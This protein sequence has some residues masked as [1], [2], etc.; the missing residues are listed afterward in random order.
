LHTESKFPSLYFPGS[1][2]AHAVNPSVE[3]Y[4]PISH[5]LQIP[6]SVKFEEY[7]PLKQDRHEPLEKAPSTTPYV[8]SLHLLHAVSPLLVEYVPLAHASQLLMEF[9]ELSLDL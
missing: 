5:D 9:Q 1:H 3:A 6:G 7:V 2:A 4:F 8:P